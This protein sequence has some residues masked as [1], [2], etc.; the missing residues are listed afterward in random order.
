[1]L[2]VVTLYCDTKKGVTLKGKFYVPLQLVFDD[3]LE[4]VKE[5]EEK[6]AKKRKRLADDFFALLC[7]IKVY[8]HCQLHY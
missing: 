8:M 1:M 4:R 6:E 5:K 2:L 7:S 3:L